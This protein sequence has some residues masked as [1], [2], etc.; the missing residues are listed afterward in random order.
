M[1]DIISKR[2]FIGG[3]TSDVSAEEIIER[4]SRFGKVSN[5]SLKNRVDETG[6]HVKSF[7]HLDLE[8]DESKI[9]KCFSTYQ[10]SKWKG[11]VLKLQYAKESFLDRL[12]R[13]RVEVPEPL[14]PETNK[15]KAPG[16]DDITGAPVPGTPVPGWTNWVVGK[17]GRVLPVLKLKKSYKIKMVKHDPSKYCHAAKVFKEEAPATEPSC[18]KLTWEIDTPETDMTR[19]RRGQFPESVASKP[20]K[21]AILFHSL[22]RQTEP[23]AQPEEELEVVHAGYKLKPHVDKRKSNIFDSDIESDS[24]M[25]PVDNTCQ[26]QPGQRKSSNNVHN[27]SKE[28][29]VHNKSKELNVHNK[30]KELDVHNKSKELD[31]HNK[32]H[33]NTKILL[34]PENGNI[35][36]VRRAPD[37]LERF[38]LGCADTSSH[39][40]PH[41]TLPAPHPTLPAPHPTL[42]APHPTLPAPHPTLPAPHPTLPAPHPTLPAPHPTLPAPHPTLPAHQPTKKNNASSQRMEFSLPKLPMFQ[43][44]RMLKD[45]PLPN[46]KICKPTAG[47]VT[48]DRG[49]GD[50]SLT[51]NGQGGGDTSLTSNGQGGGDTSLT[52]NGQGG[53]DTSL[54]SNGQGGGDTSLTS[55]GQGGG[56]TSLT[57]NGQGDGDT[58]LA[59]DQDSLNEKDEARPTVSPSSPTTL[60]AH[61]TP[62]WPIKQPASPS[63]QY[64]SD[65][66]S[67]DFESVVKKLEQ[68]LQAEKMLATAQKFQEKKELRVAAPVINT[69]HLDKQVTDNEKRLQ[70]VRQQMKLKQQ[71]KNLMSKALKDVD[72][73]E[74]NVANRIVFS[75]GSDADSDNSSDNDCQNSLSPKKNS[76]DDVKKIKLYR[77]NS[78]KDDIKKAKD[79]LTLFESSSDDESDL[80]EMFRSRPQFEGE[81][82][83]KLMKLDR[84]IGDSR[85]KIDAK[86]AESDSDGELVENTTGDQ[87][88]AEEKAASLKVLESVVGKRVLDKFSDQIKRN[89]KSII[90]MNTVR[91]DP[92]K[93]KVDK[94]NIVNKPRDLKQKIKAS[95]QLNGTQTAE[96]KTDTSNAVKQSIDPDQTDKT[97]V[98]DVKS[99]VRLTS[100][101]VSLFEEKSHVEAGFSL[102]DQFPHPQVDP[103]EG[104]SSDLPSTSGLSG[105]FTKSAQLD[106]GTTTKSAQL[107]AGTTTKSAQLD[108]GTTSKSAQLDAGT[109]TKSAQLDAG[110]TTKSAQLD[111]GTTT[112]SAQLEAGTITGGSDNL[113]QQEPSDSEGESDNPQQE[114]SD[115]EGESDN[116]GCQRYEPSLV[117]ATSENGDLLKAGQKEI[118]F[119]KEHWLQRWEEIRPL[120]VKTYKRK[121]KDAL[122]NHCSQRETK[123][124]K[125]F[126]KNSNG[127]WNRK[128]KI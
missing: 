20:K 68:K 106:A 7:A 48:L 2:L 127:L 122:K 94:P 49:G 10:N 61:L 110:T 51:S 69:Q 98:Q 101:L 29:N 71:Q 16:K 103:E 86:F 81:K 102:L 44:L 22:V 8:G 56:D 6:N 108:A 73:M 41:P 17:Y 9:K 119:T 91:F 15:V 50:T 35:S 25:L 21:A 36:A 83:E 128:K 11:S 77:D 97:K 42:P 79:A 27:K 28:L 120:I 111:A 40:A 121:H 80:E 72:T 90:D 23:A 89:T 74:K 45:F 38:E 117:D 115:S 99:S 116:P 96:G 1:T 82:G 105:L 34:N 54:T 18:D 62:L 57:S 39:P 30:S 123:R 32:K 114:P 76:K 24:E 60:A 14:K 26:N 65:L 37:D 70:A 113:T 63:G 112:K 125:E 31:V 58:S 124:K 13:E 92:T 46:D 64:D 118:R 5:L 47:L 78:S 87:S 66:D 104:K 95:P 93:L 85:F 19:K 75:S 52:S 43:G 4:F 88:L 33:L 59:H 84:K 109:T 126:L 55:N 53:G 67:N 100:S 107:D 3:L 12:A